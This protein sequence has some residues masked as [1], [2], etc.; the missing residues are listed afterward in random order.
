MTAIPAK[1]KAA[2]S[3]GPGAPL[4]VTEV[5]VPQVGHGQVLVKLESCGVCHS[6]LHLRDEALPDDAYPRI[7]GHEGIG[8]VVAVGPDTRNAPAIGARVGLPWLYDT[9]LACKPCRSGLENYCPTQQARGVEQNGAFAEYA[10]LEARFACEIP[11][12]IDPI[13]GA[14]LLCAGLTAWSALKRSKLEAGQNVLIIGAGGLG[15]Y[16]VL[17]AKARGAR[18]IVVDQDAAKLQ[19]AQSLGADWGI[20]AGP[21]AGAAVRRA[22]GADVTLNFAPTPRV[23]QTIKD[24]VNPLS[25]IV[26]VAL[27]DDP[28]DLSMLWLIDGGHRVF[29]S[30]VGTR[31]DL[32][33]FLDFAS[34]RPLGVDVE[35]VPLDQVN[36]ALDR[37]KTGDVTGR[38]CIDF[39]L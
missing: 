13:T 1:M 35:T 3:T 29:G 5:P 33:D 25:D 2:I 19:T 14:P 9:C 22:G 36:Y 20:L 16:A 11:D 8:R 38:L 39:N 21:E 15:Q 6:D 26:A 10:V 28:V 34:Q 4:V 7:F 37:L 12:Q 31:Q 23:W 32:L 18:V 30:S 27:V 24:A 17:I